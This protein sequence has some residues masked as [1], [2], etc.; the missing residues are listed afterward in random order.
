MEKE[1]V[2]AKVQKSLAGRLAL[3]LDDVKI[4]RAHV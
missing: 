1:A 2:F 4:G 3:S